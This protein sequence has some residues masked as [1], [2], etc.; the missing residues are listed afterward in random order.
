MAS[1]TVIAASMGSGAQ[2]PHTNVATHPEVL[3]PASRDLSGC[4]LSSFLCLSKDYDTL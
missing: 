4:H 2:F 1:G 3:P